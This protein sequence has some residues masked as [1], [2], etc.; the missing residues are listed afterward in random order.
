VASTSDACRDG[1]DG[2]Q[3]WRRDGSG[4]HKAPN[5]AGERD[6]GEATGWVVAGGKRADSLITGEGR[7]ADKRG[8][9]A[10]GRAVA[11][12]RER[13]RLMCGVRSSARGGE[14]GAGVGGQ[15]RWVAWVVRGAR[16]RER[17]ELGPES[18]QLGGEQ[19][20]PFL[21]IFLFPNL[22]YF[23]LFYNL[24]FPLNKYLS[25]ILGC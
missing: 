12:E 11:R 1:D 15:E 23:L 4:R 3:W 8:P 21:F 2:A 7:V 18:A 6:N 20:F 10:R 9:L 17:G 5:R 19:K 16:E 24:L 25:I 14:C 22:F 13:A